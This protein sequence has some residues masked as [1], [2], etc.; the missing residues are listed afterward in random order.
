MR[1]IVAT[2]WPYPHVG[3]ISTHIAALVSSLEA[4]G[5]QVQVISDRGRNHRDRIV[6][7]R[8]IAH[9]LARAITAAALTVDAILAQDVL[10][11]VAARD[12]I[13]WSHLPVVLTVHG[14]LA[15]EAVAAGGCRVDDPVHGFL[16][17]T[18]ERAYQVADAV[19]AVDQRLQQ[20]VARVRTGE[21]TI[22]ENA[23][24]TASLTPPPAP[25]RA[26]ARRRL[27]LGMDRLLAVCA[28]RLTAKNGVRYAIEAIALVPQAVRPL[29]VVAGD[30]EERTALQRL[31]QD[32]HVQEWVS[33][34][35]AISNEA[36]QV[37]N[38]AAD[39]ALVPSVPVAGVEEAS[40]LS[41][42]EAMALGVPLIASAV[43]GLLRV[44][45]GEGAVLV[46]PAEP[47]AL[48]AAIERLATHPEIRAEQGRR[49]RQAVVERYDTAR[50]ADTYLQVVAQ[51]VERGATPAARLADLEAR[52]PLAERVHA[53][54]VAADANEDLLVQ[55][56]VRWYETAPASFPSEGLWVLA[57]VA[58]RDADFEIAGALLFQ[59]YQQSPTVHSAELL[60][61][62]CQRHAPEKFEAVRDMVRVQV[63]ELA[64][65]GESHAG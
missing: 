31:V 44:G 36:V 59:A 5:H 9:S 11:A 1:L 62:F 27:G 37:L 49:G 55:A 25:V 47:Q 64:D 40:S 23:V 65:L 3:G 6:G 24:D 22:L 10:A 18:E 53:V 33:F 46:P 39:I 19:I 41:A 21:A 32:L 61:G 58:E 2:Q 4:R 12:A 63:G 38:Q 51:A 14:Y 26:D 28:R 60:L 34:Y 35:G 54:A 17:A 48:A 56:L 8:E 52:L 20:H 13:D 45:A 16:L 7:D 50:W 29:L 30:G 57:K 15:A 42:L 43:G